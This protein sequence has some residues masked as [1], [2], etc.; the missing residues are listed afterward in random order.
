[1][2]LVTVRNEKPG[3]SFTLKLPKKEERGKESNNHQS[4]PD[5]L[6]RWL[7]ISS[8]FEAEIYIIFKAP[9]QLEKNNNLQE[10]LQAIVHPRTIPTIDGT[11]HL[12]GKV[13]HIH[14]N[15]ERNTKNQI[16]NISA[17]YQRHRVIEISD[18]IK[19]FP[20]HIYTILTVT[21]T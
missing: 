7:S 10:A 17:I 21:P 2:I 13:F 20:F 1:M 11:K 18:V 12:L 15:Y 5:L 9:K 16:N 4:R 14:S 3:Y 8:V 6:H 19:G